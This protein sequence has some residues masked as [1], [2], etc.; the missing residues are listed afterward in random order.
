M[1]SAP[2]EP[3]I[4]EPGDAVG[5]AQRRAVGGARHMGVDVDQAGHHQLAAHVHCFGGAGRDIWFHRGDTA[6]GDGHVA[7]RVQLAR[8]IDD[9]SALEDQI[10]FAFFCSE[11]ARHTDQCRSRLR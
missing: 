6:I 10:V 4:D 3:G 11:R 7:D 2:W 9:A 1:W 8:R 5:Q